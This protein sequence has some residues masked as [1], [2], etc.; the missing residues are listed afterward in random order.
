MMKKIMSNLLIVLI[1]I[2]LLNI[3]Y[4][5]LI[6]KDNLIKV[7][8]K[9]FVIVTTGSMEPEIKPGELVIIS[10]IENY[11]P[12]DIITYQDNEGF[13]VTHRIT[14]I[15]QDS[16]IAKGDA[17]NLSD[18]E[19]SNSNIKGKVIY[20]S[21]ILGSF[22]LY[23]LKPLVIIYVA[24]FIIIN[25]YFYIVEKIIEKDEKRES[26]N[27]NECKTNNIVDEH[28]EKIGEKQVQKNSKNMS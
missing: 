14:E 7:F 13:L 18:E 10:E 3:C 26:D 1:I 8:G 15:N 19:N 22:V 28:L 23:F 21:K 24:L 20:H 11:K 9:A 12:G 25:L 2:F 17:N 27:I 5:K 6:I 4:S 16:F